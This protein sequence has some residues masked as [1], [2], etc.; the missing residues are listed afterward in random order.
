MLNQIKIICADVFDIQRRRTLAAKKSDKQISS[1]MAMTARAMIPDATELQELQ[2]SLME[3]SAIIK[4][5]LGKIEE[6]N[7]LGMKAGMEQM[8]LNLGGKNEP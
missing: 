2:I 7:E 4:E 8:I 5:T 6:L 3:E 1:V